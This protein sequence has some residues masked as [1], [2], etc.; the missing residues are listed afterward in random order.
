MTTEAPRLQLISRE[1]AFQAGK[2]RYYTGEACRT[3]HVAERYVSNGACV[4]CVTGKFK[5]R[6]NPFSRDLAPFLPQKL[7]VPR[8]VE[9]TDYPSLEK[10]LQQC[11]AEY[12]KHTGKLTPGLEEAFSM[13]LEKM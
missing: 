8:S 12:V 4:E 1:A 11:I 10:Y 13:Q 9:P 2:R 7:W 6:Q 5:Y 3:G